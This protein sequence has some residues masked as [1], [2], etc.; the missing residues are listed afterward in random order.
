MPQFDGEIQAFDPY[1]VEARLNKAHDAIIG[2][3]G[4]NHARIN[5]FATDE[6]S[7]KM[8]QPCD[9]SADTGNMPEPTWVVERRVRYLFDFDDGVVGIDVVGVEP[10]VPKFDD[11]VVGGYDG[12]VE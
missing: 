1:W 3:I 9:I 12:E 8:L 4:A 2:R 10:Y 6:F 5:H 7:I 11:G